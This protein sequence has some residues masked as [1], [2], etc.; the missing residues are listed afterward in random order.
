MREK[1][2]ASRYEALHMTERKR[3]WERCL[4]R[5]RE[6][7]ISEERERERGAEGWM[8]LLGA[9]QDLRSTSSAAPSQY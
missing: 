5:V 7:E 8:F 6:K 1:L 2:R 3:E 4:K 9:I